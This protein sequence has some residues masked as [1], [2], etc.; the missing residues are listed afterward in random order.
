MQAHLEMEAYLK[1][2]C[3]ALEGVRYTIVR[4]GIYCES[5]ALY[6]GFF[7]PGKAVGKGERRVVSVPEGADRG[8]AWVG[9]DELGEGTARILLRKEEFA[10]Q[11]VLL[12]GG[13]AVSIKEVAGIISGVMGWGGKEAVGV[14]ELGKE[15]WLDAMVEMKTGK[16]E[17]E[18]T[19]AFMEKWYTTYPAIGKGELDVVDP[20]LE[21]LLGRKLESME[22]SLRRQLKDVR[23]ARESIG[24]YAR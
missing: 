4:E 2:T 18:E 14:E 6:L 10:D 8:V 3:A 11:T 23:G 19:R 21:M 12:S 13:A 17:D 24:Q 5:W 9:R 7:D 16:K 20:L 1:R 22:E 15:R